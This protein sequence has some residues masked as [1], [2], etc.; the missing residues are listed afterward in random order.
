[1][2]R[3]DPVS[4]SAK[5]LPVS[6]GSF[7]HIRDDLTSI[8]FATPE[9]TGE[10]AHPIPRLAYWGA[11]LSAGADLHALV[12]L[13]ARATPHAAAD[14][15]L[16]RPMLPMGA[17]GWRL[18]PAVQ[19]SRPG[20][21]DWSPKFKL[22]GYEAQLRPDGTASGVW[23][24]MRD[25]VARLR[26]EVEIALVR[27]VLLIDQSLRNEADTDY[28]LSGLA[29]TLPLPARATE[30]V[31]LTGRWCR[32]RT[33]QRH[34]LPFGTWS[35]ETR[36]GRTG[37]DGPLLLMVGTAGF[38]FGTGEVWALHLGWSGDSVLWAER[39]PAGF[40]QVG[41][42]EL[43]APGEVRLPPGGSYQAPTAFA[44]YSG[45]GMDGVSAA[46]H[47]YLRGRSG[48]P[49]TPRPVLLNTW[50][51]VYFDQDLGRLTELA[52]AAAAVGVERFVLDDGWFGGRRGDHA[53]LGDW[54][55]SADVWPDGLR[56]LI[57]AVTS[58]G[59]D[60]GLWVEPEM[61]NPDSDLYRAH[62]D[63][64]LQ[65]PG[66]LGPTWRNQYVLDLAR[67]EV[68]AYLLG[69]LD[70]LLTENDI[71][72]LKWDHNRDLVDAGHGGVP[73]VRTQT[74][75]LYELLDELRRRH[76]GVEIETCA[77]GGGRVDLGILARTDR[78][79]ASDTID[80]HERQLIQRWT[81][82]V[83][84]P[85]LVGSHV[86]SAKAHTTGRVLS[87]SFRAATA[88]FGHLGV[89]ADLS[90]AAE[91][92]RR[93]I[94]E[95]IAVYKEHRDWLHRGT[96]IRL[97]EPD[98]DALAHGI[99]AADQT[100]ALF[101]YVRLATAPVEV[102]PPLRLRGL[103]PEALYRVT[104]VTIAGGPT[105][106]QM[107]TCAWVAAGGAVASGELLMNVGVSL[108]VLHPDQAFLVHLRRE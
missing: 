34:P 91:T 13:V 7:V 108:P 98:P 85:E 24:T 4:D 62:P 100:Q 36:R 54:V 19:G 101:S 9:P 80:A 88:L 104:P 84:P 40:A 102:L 1:M 30:I 68:S 25:T 10:E 75:A 27:G 106:Q 53:G 79:W 41:A 57:E 51:A 82:L 49:S 73:G 90:R 67:P 14:V 70:A 22:T 39:S 72:Y 81:G 66:R 59:M 48:H 56:P 86:G 76:P 17:D 58:R 78:I 32:E 61:V 94:A 8:V 99:V 97:D 64:L 12:Q 35:R 77:S 69:Q 93:G 105:T 71:A 18:R 3:I 92:D 60:F 6:G 20:G 23:F 5:G 33:P 43:L 29:A 47:T 31:D 83:V 21:G 87:L 15:P 74:L 44:V 55:V 50:E 107:A 95:A 46:F 16:E 28:L 45:V 2:P 42:A 103:D 38:A 26:V 96:S 65:V 52:D 63:W 89:E 11:A 37:H